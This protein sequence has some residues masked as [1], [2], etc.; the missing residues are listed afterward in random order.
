MYPNS[1]EEDRIGVSSC[2]RTPYDP[3]VYTRISTSRASLF[4]YTSVL[5]NLHC[6]TLS[7]ESQ[8]ASCCVEFASCNMYQSF[9]WDFIY[10]SFPT[11]FVP[12]FSNGGPDKFLVN[13]SL[14]FKSPG[15]HS[16]SM[17][18]AS[19]SSLRNS[20]FT[21]MCRVLPPT[22]QLSQRSFAP[23]LSIFKIIGFFYL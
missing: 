8:K 17:S 22:L 20:C 10:L 2:I 11:N 18:F 4:T 16:L 6:D 21:S 14:E 23:L 1:I 3:Y 19:L 5:S 15:I 12:C 13:I 9:L 7:F